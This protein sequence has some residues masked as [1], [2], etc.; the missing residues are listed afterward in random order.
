MPIPVTAIHKDLVP[1]AYNFSI[2]LS[3]AYYVLQSA[4][5]TYCSLQGFNTERADVARMLR[6]LGVLFSWKDY[7]LG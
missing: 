4:K 2:V 6:T 1:E 3:L 7:K 5:L